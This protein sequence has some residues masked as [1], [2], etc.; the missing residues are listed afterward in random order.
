MM[1]FI[2]KLPCGSDAEFDYAAGHGYRC[3]SCNAVVGSVGMPSR[4][5]SQINK[6]D[7]LKALGSSIRWNYETGQEVDVSH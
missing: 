3:T 1:S 7:V 5:K 6:Y 4:C 2:M